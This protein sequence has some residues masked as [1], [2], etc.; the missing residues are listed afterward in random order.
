MA[1]SKP[2]LTKSLWQYSPTLGT[3][4]GAGK[5]NEAAIFSPFIDLSSLILAPT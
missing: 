3:N 1:C 4:D 2:G 5:R